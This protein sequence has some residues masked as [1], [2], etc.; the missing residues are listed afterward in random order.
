MNPNSE[1]DSETGF[2][3]VSGNKR[4]QQSQQPF[5]QRSQP[6]KQQQSQS[7]GQ[8][9]QSQ[10]I[11]QP[12]KQ[13]QRPFIPQLIGINPFRSQE[14]W[15]EENI[16]KVKKA[17][18]D[19][20]IDTHEKLRYIIGNQ[21][22][23]LKRLANGSLEKVFIFTVLIEEKGNYK[24]MESDYD[25]FFEEH[26]KFLK[27]FFKGSE[28]IS[29]VGIAEKINKN[30]VEYKSL[31]YDKDELKLLKWF[32]ID[33]PIFIEKNFSKI[34]GSTDKTHYKQDDETRKKLKKS[35]NAFLY[36][37]GTPFDIFRKKITTYFKGKSRYD[38]FVEL[39]INK[40]PT[41]SK[42]GAGQLFFSELEQ[43]VKILKKE[44]ELFTLFLDKYPAEKASRLFND[45]TSEDSL[46]NHMIVER[47]FTVTYENILTFKTGLDELIR[48]AS[49]YQKY[50]KYANSKGISLDQ[51]FYEKYLL[52][53]TKYLKL[54]KLVDSYIL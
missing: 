13:H 9:Q 3:T 40:Y 15:T 31:P 45:K 5:K 24:I 43:A 23:K 33:N 41:L 30:F 10:P 22:K 35:V 52:Y 21:S 38:H 39:Y 17:I 4:K 16:S 50:L 49:N 7:T 48:E 54:K 46:E 11:R 51:V 14:D 47:T 20:L 6:I 34:K 26:S 36:S 44:N 53:K 32:E 2:T 42:E 19:G 12:T 28:L 27:K 29:G 8:E 1:N 18:E 37:K 25:K